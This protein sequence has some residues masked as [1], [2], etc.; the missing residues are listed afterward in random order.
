[1]ARKQI[2]LTLLPETDEKLT[3]IAK[4]RL[5]TKGMVVDET[6]AKIKEP[7]GESE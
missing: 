7:K 6:I 1:M 5:V 4:S 2:T 3:R